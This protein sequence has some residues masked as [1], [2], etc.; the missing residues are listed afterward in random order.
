MRIRKLQL[1][2]RQTPTDQNMMVL[3]F[4]LAF[5]QAT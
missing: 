5:P 1:P 2:Y 3:T 4:R